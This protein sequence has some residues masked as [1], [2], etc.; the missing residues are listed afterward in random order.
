[1]TRIYDVRFIP[2]RQH[3]LYRIHTPEATERGT[4]MRQGKI[5][6]LSI[7][8]AVPRSHPRRAVGRKL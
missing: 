5:Q 3:Y 4:Y 7:V 1:M 2:A 8:S 6:C